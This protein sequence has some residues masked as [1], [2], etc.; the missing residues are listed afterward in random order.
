MFRIELAKRNGDRDEYTGTFVRT[1]LKRG[2]VKPIP[3]VLIKDIRD[4]TTGALMADHLWFKL[5]KGFQALNLQA[6]DIVSFRGR[7]QIYMKGYKGNRDDVEGNPIKLDFMLARPTK[8]Q[9]IGRCEA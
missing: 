8:I 5:T 3:T 6:N 7:A 9:K 1:G 4:R 2:H